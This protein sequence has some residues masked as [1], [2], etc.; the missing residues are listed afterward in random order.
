MLVT[1]TVPV[2]LIIVTGPPS[3]LVRAWQPQ[4]TLEQRD[5]KP[6]VQGHGGSA[7]RKPPGIRSKSLSL[8]TEYTV[9]K[10]FSKVSVMPKISRTIV[11]E[12]WKQAGEEKLSLNLMTIIINMLQS[13]CL[14]SK[15]GLRRAT[16]ATVL[17]RGLETQDK[18][19]PES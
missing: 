5:V 12:V 3:E 13:A 15:Q 6:A 4:K 9:F 18:R 1:T 2:I 8:K 17:R 11:L 10:R 16:S 7:L 14:L 19:Y